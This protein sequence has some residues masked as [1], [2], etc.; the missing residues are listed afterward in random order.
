MS[1]AQ[2]YV[3]VENAPRGKEGYIGKYGEARFS[4]YSYS[5]DQNTFSVRFGEDDTQSFCEKD[6][7]FLADG[8]TPE[9]DSGNRAIPEQNIIP[10]TMPP[11][12]GLAGYAGVGKDEVLKV[13]QANGYEHVEFSDGVRE[14]LYA[15]DPYVPVP[16]EDDEGVVYQTE[17]MRVT[18]LLE[19]YGYV[20]AKR[21]C[22]EFRRLLQ[23]YGTKAGREI[24]GDDCWIEKWHRDTADAPKVGVPSVRFPNEVEAI[25]ERGGEV[26]LVT[27]PGYGRVNDHES[28]DMAEDWNANPSKADRVIRNDGSLEDLRKAVEQALVF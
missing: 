14:G 4:G 20:E 27:R 18:E 16:L 11:V 13:L 17:W 26:W 25:H 6:L 8:E 15:M 7:R 1:N 10:I 21:I 23:D 19:C 3:R 22:P 28:E 24:H 9:T 5:K 12:I 2:G